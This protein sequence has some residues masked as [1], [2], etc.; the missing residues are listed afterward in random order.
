MQTR[1]YILNSFMLHKQKQP[2]PVRQILILIV[3]KYPNDGLPG[4][5]GE[6]G[7]AELKGKISDYVT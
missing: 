3:L 6:G 2:N 4:K 1:I 7:Q 5:V